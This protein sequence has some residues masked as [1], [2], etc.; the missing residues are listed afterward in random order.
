M[1]SH[2][3]GHQHIPV[4]IDEEE[5]NILMAEV[6]E[7]GMKQEKKITKWYMKDENN[8]PPIYVLLVCVFF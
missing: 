3:Y 6:T 7:L 5:F 4:E 2:R 1:L 8:V